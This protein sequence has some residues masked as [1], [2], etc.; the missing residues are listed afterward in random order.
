MAVS[1]TIW[2]YWG[3]LLLLTFGAMAVFLVTAV[4]LMVFLQRRTKN[5]GI[6]LLPVLLIVPLMTAAFTYLVP[7]GEQSG[8]LYPEE[9]AYTHT[10]A[11][12]ITAVRPADH[13]PLY[14]YDGEFRGGVY[15][16]IDGTEYY[17][18]SHPLL[19]V[20]TSLHFTYCPEDDLIMAF[21]PIAAGEVAALQAPFVMPDPVPKESL[22]EEP[23]PELAQDVG[24]LLHQLGFLSLLALI[25]LDQGL[26]K[27]AAGYLQ[28]QDR[29][30]RFEVVPNRA[31]LVTTTL[32]LIPFTLMALGEI[33]AAGSWSI[34]F[35]LIPV[36][37]V[38]F[39]LTWYSRASIRVEGRIIRIRRFGRERTIPLSALRS[40][41]WESSRHPFSQ[42][43]L[44]LQFEDGPLRLDQTSHL[45]LEDL[46]RRLSAY[47]KSI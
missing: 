43:Q 2:D 25:L 40:I 46:H 6:A 47:L 17:S 8:C 19:T 20:G 15:L 10:T 32:F 16:T 26:S 37:S 42:R 41:Y 30:Q 9:N 11:G 7:V 14:H 34:L 35:L 39:S 12:T 21:S 44:V 18:M 33:L 28:A 3:E 31:V 45:G 1:F 13:I 5:V 22:P 4:P 29:R 36:A 38:L 23:M 27:Q 24:S